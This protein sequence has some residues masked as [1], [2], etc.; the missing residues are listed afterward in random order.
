MNEKSCK[1]CLHYEVCLNMLRTFDEKILCSKFIDRSEWVHLPCKVGDTMFITIG[2][3]IIRYEIKR[4]EIDDLMIWAKGVNNDYAL[5]AQTVMRCISFDLGKTIFLSEEE[6]RKH[7][8][9]VKGNDN[10][11]Q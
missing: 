5:D 3:S 9:K 8:R 2:D 1:G 10:T 11:L 4:F 6:A 7:L